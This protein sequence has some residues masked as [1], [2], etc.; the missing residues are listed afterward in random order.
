VDDPVVDLLV[1]LGLQQQ[2]FRLGTP[3][4][5]A[6]SKFVA[7]EHEHRTPGGGGDAREGRNGGQRQG[8]A[9]ERASV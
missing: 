3:D 7:D 4:L 6:A 5:A 2:R 1:D 8:A 9:C